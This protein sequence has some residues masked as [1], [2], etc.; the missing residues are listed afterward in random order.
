MNL[1]L[2]TFV[3]SLLIGILG[4]F[5]IRTLTSIDQ[6]IVDLRTELQRKSDI[7]GNHETRLQILEKI[8]SLKKEKEK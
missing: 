7:V 3:M 8:E 1:K 6:N 4:F 5:I 2:L